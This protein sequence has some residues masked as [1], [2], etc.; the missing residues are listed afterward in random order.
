MEDKKFGSEKQTM[1]TGL[2]QETGTVNELK[3][4][5]EGLRMLLDAEEFL[6][7]AQKGGSISIS[8]ACLT[9]EAFREE[10]VE[11]FL[12]EE[13]LEKTWF[14]DLSR[15]D[16]LNLEKALKPE[17]RMGGHMVQGHVETYVQVLDIQE[18]EEGWNMRFR[19]PEDLEDYI[20]KKGFI[21]VEGISLTVVDTSDESF[22]VTIIPE[23]WR[24]TNLSEKTEGDEVNIE[25]DIMA[26]YAEKMMDREA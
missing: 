17:E 1:F 26:R 13:T 3:E 7:D 4:A 23:T 6:E 21:A 24:K 2:V 12:A 8:G 25:T 16:K 10:G 15:G 9:V 5:G 19:M 20:V 11:F 18:L 14:S 22:S